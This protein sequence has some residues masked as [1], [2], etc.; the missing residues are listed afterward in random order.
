MVAQSILLLNASYEPLTVVP[1]ARQQ[2]CVDALSA[3]GGSVDFTVYPGVGHDAWTPTYHDP[4]A[5]D[6]LFAQRRK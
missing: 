2:A 3:C 6:W 1:L 4:A 5:L